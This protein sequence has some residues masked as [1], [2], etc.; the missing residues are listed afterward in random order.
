MV[1]PIPKIPTRGLSLPIIRQSVR[2]SLVG[3]VCACVSNLIIIGSALAGINDQV[4]IILAVATVTPLGYILQSWFT[5]RSPLSM[6]RFMRF[7][8]GIGVGTLWFVLLMTLFQRIIG[9]PVWIASPLT[10]FLIF[11]WNFAASR[12][13]ILWR[14]QQ[15]IPRS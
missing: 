8:G 15:S 10:T 14:M 4:A 13:A 7:L 5:Y 1:L 12:W 6:Q 2:Y 9:M 3:I 11:I